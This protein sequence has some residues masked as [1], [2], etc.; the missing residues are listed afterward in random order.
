M[1]SPMPKFELGRVVATPGAL[2]A[3][4]SSGQSPNDFL[5]R[6]FNGDWGEHLDGH[7]IKQNVIALSE[8]GRTESAYQTRKGEDL[9]VITEA[10][11]R[12]P[13]GLRPGVSEAPE[14]G[15][16]QWPDP[17][18]QLVRHQGL[19]RDITSRAKRAVRVMRTAY[20]LSHTVRA[21]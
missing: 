6:R 5:R 11:W 8:D 9:W 4:R 10:A 19:D 15:Q 13:I 21:S 3:T 18:P 12:S 7:D 14:L 1:F 20:R 2:R 16:Q 17:F